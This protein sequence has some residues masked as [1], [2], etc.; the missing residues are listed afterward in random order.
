MKLDGIG[1]T[2]RIDE[3]LRIKKVSRK[4]LYLSLKLA[5]NTFSN[6]ETRGTVPAADI[7]LKIADYLGVSVRWLVTGKDDQGLTLEERNLLAKYNS[8]DNRDRYEV[9][10]LLD[11]KL[12]GDLLGVKDAAN[13]QGA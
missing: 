4:E 8:L 6:W 1:I 5:F 12:S 2:A 9:N 13:P 7:A 10:A 11:A 3:A